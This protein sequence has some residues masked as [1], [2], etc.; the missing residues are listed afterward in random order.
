MMHIL[1]KH[2]RPIVIT[3]SV[4]ILQLLFGFDPKF[5]AINIIWLLV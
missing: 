5:C 1:Q 4:I 3:L 2:R